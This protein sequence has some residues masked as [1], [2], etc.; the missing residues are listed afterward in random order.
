MEIVDSTSGAVI[1][2]RLYR[3]ICEELV[4]ELGP[5]PTAAVKTALVLTID[6]FCWASGMTHEEFARLLVEQKGKRKRPSD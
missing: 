3:R 6:S 5:L 4:E 2:K 1:A